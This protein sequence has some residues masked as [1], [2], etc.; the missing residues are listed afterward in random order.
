[1]NA[2]VSQTS[3]QLV[4]DEEAEKTGPE[5]H[6]YQPFSGFPYTDATTIEWSPDDKLL[7]TVGRSVG[8][9]EKIPIIWDVKSGK[10]IK[11]CESDEL[12]IW[13]EDGS[14]SVRKSESDFRYSPNRKYALKHNNDY[15]E[16][17]MLNVLNDS[18][19]YKIYTEPGSLY[20]IFWSPD[21]TKLAYN[22]SETGEIKV[23][24]TET[25]NVSCTF[26]SPKNLQSLYFS[27]KSTYL[28][29]T[30]SLNE[31]SD[32]NAEFF[33]RLY[34]LQS[35][36]VAMDSTVMIGSYIWNIVWSSDEKS[37][38]VGYKDTFNIYKLL[39]YGMEKKSSAP[40][41]E[42]SFDK[43]ESRRPLFYTPDNNYIVCSSGGGE[44]SFYEGM[45]DIENEKF[46]SF[47]EYNITPFSMRFSNDGSR[48]ASYFSALY[49]SDSWTWK[50]HLSVGKFIPPN[51]EIKSVF[52]DLKDLGTLS[53]EIEYC[54]L[55]FSKDGAYIAFK[56]S[57]YRK[58]WMREVLYYWD[59]RNGNVKS[60]F[61][62]DSEY[63]WSNDNKYLLVHDDENIIIWDVLGRKAIYEKKCLVPIKYDTTS[64]NGRYFCWIENDNTLSCYDIK[65]DCI[66]N[67]DDSKILTF[68]DIHFRQWESNGDYL[69]LELEREKR[70]GFLK[71][72]TGD[73]FLGPAAEYVY[74]EVD[75]W[76]AN[77]IKMHIG[78]NYFSGQYSLWDID[79]ECVIEEYVDSNFQISPNKKILIIDSYDGNGK[80]IGTYLFNSET[81]QKYNTDYETK[82]IFDPSEKYVAIIPTEAGKNKFKILETSA[83]NE[84][85]ESP[86]C[87]CSTF[88]W[89][90]TD[91]FFK[92]DE[93][94]KTTL[95]EVG[96]E[97]SAM[98]VYYGGNS[99]FSPNGRYLC[100]HESYPGTE[101]VI[102]DLVKKNKSVIRLDT[103][104]D[105]SGVWSE[106]SRYVCVK[107]DE[108][109]TLIY[110]VKDNK[111]MITKSNRD[112]KFSP[113][114]HYLCSHNDSMLEVI[115][116][117]DWNKHS[118]GMS[119]EEYGIELKWSD[120][121]SYLLIFI[122]D[123]ILVYDVKNQK[124]GN[125]M[126]YF[127]EGD[128]SQ[129]P[130]IFQKIEGKTITKFGVTGFDIIDLPYDYGFTDGYVPK[131][132][133]YNLK[134]G[135]LLCTTV[136]CPDGEYL[137][138]TPEGFFTGTDWAC[139]N[140]VYIVDG[141]EVTELT[142]LYDKLY[143]PDLVAA[144]MRGEDISEEAA[145]VDLDSL[146]S[147]G[148]PPKLT[149]LDVPSKSKTG[150]LTF[151]FNIKDCGGGIGAVYASV[152]GQVKKVRDSVSS[153]PGETKK[154]SYTLPLKDGENVIEV[155]AYNSAGVIESLRTKTTVTWHS[156]LQIQRPDLYVLAVGINDYGGSMDLHYAVPDA[157]SVSEVFGKQKSGLYENVHVSLLLNDKGSKQEIESEFN[158][159]SKKIKPDDVFVF[160]VSGHGSLVGGDYYFITHDFADS[161]GDIDEYGISKRDIADYFTPINAR[162][163]L[164]I[165]DSCHSGAA[166]DSGARGMDEAVAIKR[167]VRATGQATLAAFGDTQSSWEGYNGHGVFTYVLVEGLEG[168]ADMDG[169]GY[170]SVT[171]LAL[172]V[173][174]EVPIIAEEKM[175]SPQQQ[176]P[177]KELVNQDFP[178][179]GASH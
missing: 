53:D 77:Y 36:N 5:L 147:T 177:K 9:S 104:L 129:N 169:D 23:I 179:A 91:C 107:T 37:I 164:I 56:S 45:L 148:T 8:G 133:L 128:N 43:Y 86:S 84:I 42:Y 173:E 163:T 93:Y 121:S 52:T 103:S 178:L 144:K 64:P 41:L 138:Y 32:R 139:H 146:L 63:L 13:N 126:H 155:Y 35:G 38:C 97:I 31:A 142:Q 154:L 44:E 92:F 94:N 135:E 168:K 58:A 161:D 75:Y 22:D 51:E 156:N 122:N 120:D 174:R 158:R 69:L 68:K 100:A 25:G 88:S 157:T 130:F 153:N 143:R 11:C 20:K 132:Q 17:E 85:Y 19:M 24:E 48:V 102:I 83:F 134:T 4:M 12:I 71:P 95:V 3:R 67:I 1:M 114:G 55:G 90:V 78:E 80:L 6:F 109:G 54:P 151:S 7:M 165:L 30:Y 79:Q 65:E 14:Y 62:I 66:C 140:L 73:L 111:Q 108:G 82:F 33:F 145:K 96:E 125:T 76:N 152:N 34:D 18:V 87:Y 10:Q 118:V 141:L 21:S 70:Y 39:M 117:S 99:S 136:A 50:Y 166:I 115:D 40:V 112:L 28:A 61:G 119:F 110:D 116:L 98:E 167:L 137:T 124:T 162:K 172:Y 72:Q 149:L 176:N 57:E 59:I 160:Y 101:L 113:D 106:N 46:I 47:R 16:H 26:Q 27:P 131:V 89:N 170:V 29:V 159:I 171:E 123:S 175:S 2:G 74:P 105:Y 127:S 49:D 150:N 15:T 81:H 60:P